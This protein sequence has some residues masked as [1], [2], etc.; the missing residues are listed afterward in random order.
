MKAKLLSILFF[1]QYLDKPTY[2]RSVTVGLI[3]AAAILFKQTVTVLL[4]AVLI[5]GA[6][7]QRR[8]ALLS[9]KAAPAYIFVFIALVITVVHATKFGGQGLTATVGDGHSLA[10]M[11]AKRFSLERWLLHP[12]MLLHTWGWP[13]LVLSAIGAV[14]PSQGNEPQLPLLRIWFLWW[15]VSSSLLF[16][17]PSVAN[18]GRYTLYVFPA[19][20]MLAARPVFL[21]Q[22][23]SVAKA[24]FLALFLAILTFNSWRSIQQP[25]PH[26]DGYSEISDF[27]YQVQTK[28]PILFAGKYDGSFIFNLK[29]NDSRRENIVLRA[30]KIF[31]SMAVHKSFGVTSYVNGT[32]DILSMI[33]KYRVEYIVIEQPDVIGLKEVAMLY[34][35]LQQPEFVKVRSF[36]I[37]ATHVK[38]ADR[39]EIY[40]YKNQS[41]DNDSEIVIH[42]PHMG[43]DIRFKRSVLRPLLNTSVTGHSSQP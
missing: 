21:L 25:V 9:W 8:S 39:I 28:G 23:Y 18:A 1:E 22:P 29:R 7:S 11:A 40:R 10:G 15:Y 33:K 38:A 31:V 30:D 5:Y 34:D 36:S 37:T 43:R 32:D 42:L 20:A 6:L 41:I 26:V 27:M 4:P 24:A 2:W 12:S 14:W 35:L 17:S 19:L 3:M 13:L 16:G